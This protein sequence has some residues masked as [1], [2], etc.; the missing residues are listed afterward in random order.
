MNFNQVMRTEHVL[1][2]TF[3]RL[4][5]NICNLKIEALNYLSLT[6]QMISATVVASIK[7][8]SKKVTY[9]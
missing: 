3:I 4:F 2:I 1:N 8:I 5:V 9:L 6:A 7:L